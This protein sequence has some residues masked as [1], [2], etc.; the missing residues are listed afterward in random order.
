MVHLI[1]VCIHHMLHV[2]HQNDQKVLD[3]GAFHIF[4]LKEPNLRSHERQS[5]DLS[6]WGDLP[7][8]WAWLEREEKGRGHVKQ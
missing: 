6:A 2:C 7:V 3:F 1:F 8:I 5:R 4:E